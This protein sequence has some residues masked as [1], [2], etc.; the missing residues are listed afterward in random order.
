MV[1]KRS[2]IRIKLLSDTE[3]HA[4]V[5]EPQSYELRTFLWTTRFSLMCNMTIKWKQITLTLSANIHKSVKI[6]QICK[7]T[8][9]FN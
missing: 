1:S 3:N 6:A 4:L 5:F 8:V 7:Q 9:H 2:D